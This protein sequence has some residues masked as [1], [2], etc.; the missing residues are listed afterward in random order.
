[1]IASCQALGVFVH[2]AGIVHCVLGR[3]LT[4]GKW[5]WPC[6]KRVGL[7]QL[8]PMSPRDRGPRPVDHRAVHR[9]TRPVRST[10]GD[11]SSTVDRPRHVCRVA[12]RCCQHQT[13][14]CRCLYRTRRQLL[15]RCEI[16]TAYSIGRGKP[17]RKISARS[18]RP[19]RCNTGV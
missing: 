1:V 12:A 6:S 4:A 16:F 7:Y 17:A 9:A 3:R 15:C 19:F 10:V 11:R 8:T 5:A 2:S 14:C 13:A 18:V